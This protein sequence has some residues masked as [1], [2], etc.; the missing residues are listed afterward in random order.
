MTKTDVTRKY[1]PMAV[2]LAISPMTVNLAM[3][4]IIFGDYRQKPQYYEVKKCI[5]MVV[6]ERI[7]NRNFEI[8]NKFISDLSGYR[9]KIDTIEN[10]L[11]VKT[12]MVNTGIIP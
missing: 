4:G 5:R 3:N 9:S 11:P 10:G 6:S 1:R 12:G 2:I 8:F 7:S